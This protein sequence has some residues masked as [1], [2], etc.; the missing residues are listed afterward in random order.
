MS[1]PVIHL[2]VGVAKTGTSALQ[3]FLADNRE[4][5]GRQGLLV[6]RTGQR[7]D[8]PHHALVWQLAGLGPGGRGAAIGRLAEEL[9]ASGLPAAVIS[10][11]YALPL[12]RASLLPWSLRRLRSMGFGLRVHCFVRPQ[13]DWLNSAWPELLRSTLAPQDFA[14]FV[15]ARR[16]R[17]RPWA[18][19]VG[20]FARFATAPPVLHPFTRAARRGGLWLPFLEGLGIDPGAEDWA[21]PG[22]VNPTLGP[23]GT[24]ATHAIVK[25]LANRGLI[26][27][28]R[29]RRAIRDRLRAAT[30]RFPPEGRAFAGLRPEEAAAIW[31]ETAEANDALARAAWGQPWDAV[32]E[33]ERAAPVRRNAYHPRRARPGEREAE[34]E[35]IALAWAAVRRAVRACEARSAARR[36]RDRLRAP[37]D[38]LLDAS[39]R[40]GLSL[41]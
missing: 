32:F 9:R 5:L 10:S 33:E 4:G 39:F 13:A 1:G 14:D 3:R 19:L 2:H 12:M 34:E 36:F 38:R 24:Y 28:F 16:R 22:E 15:A 26:G 11:E 41:G 8:G 6:P 27:G 21:V 25:R 37:F 7:A 40:L 18:G 23:I 35:M 31:A 17:L 30:L 29:D 20:P